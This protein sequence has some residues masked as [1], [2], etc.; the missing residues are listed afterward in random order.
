[1]ALAV[2]DYAPQG[3]ALWHQP[4]LVVR[5]VLGFYGL[6]WMRRHP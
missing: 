1:M 2:V 6:P 4:T 5:R 3:L